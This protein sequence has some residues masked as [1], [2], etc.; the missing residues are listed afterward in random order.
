MTLWSMDDWRYLRRETV[1]DPQGRAWS[2]A[3]MDVLGQ[4]GDPE[5]P[6]ELLQLQYA[7]GRYFTLVYSRTGALQREDAYASL[8][9]AT[10]A[11]DG[12]IAAVGDGRLDPAQPV[13][14]ERDED[15]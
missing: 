12:L 10:T 3:L 4:E 13:F 6:N 1:T 15:L 5:L 7:S 14:V 2:I 8:S 11:Y 9:E